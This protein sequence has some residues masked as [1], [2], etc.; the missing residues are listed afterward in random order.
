MTL[1]ERIQ[2]NM[3]DAMRAKDEL[4]LSVL[5]MLLAAVHNRE[6]EKRE[7]LNDEENLATIRTEV[8]KRKDAAEQFAKGG[9]ED[10]ASKEMQ[11]L[12]IL[13]SYLPVEMNDEDLEKVVREV[14]SGLGGVTI[15]DFG[16]VMAE[17]MKKIKGQAGGDRVSAAVRK[18]LE[19]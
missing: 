13:G 9:R 12:E 3:K 15:K 11:E 16:R 10:L 1:K 4:R 18:Y 17:A 5:R 2:S 14:I 7:E 8:K 6:I 19:K